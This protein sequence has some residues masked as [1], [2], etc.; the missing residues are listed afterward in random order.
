[1]LEASV[2]GDHST[3]FVSDF[4]YFT[5]TLVKE[6]TFDPLSKTPPDDKGQKATVRRLIDAGFV[7]EIATT[8]TY[9]DIWARTP[10]MYREPVIRRGVRENLNPQHL[11]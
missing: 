8:L 11:R 5:N 3:D 2:G 10:T 6:K 9:P 1:M 4:A 7:Q